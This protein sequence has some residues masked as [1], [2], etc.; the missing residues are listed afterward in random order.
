[1]FPSLLLFVVVVV[2]VVVVLSYLAFYLSIS[3]SFRY[4]QALCN[5]CNLRA[6][7]LHTKSVDSIN[8]F[9]HNLTR[10]SGNELK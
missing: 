4:R 10:V 3:V 1:M 9:F 5:Y 6:T 2:V 8:F 7:N